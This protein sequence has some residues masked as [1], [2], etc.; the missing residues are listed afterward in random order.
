[1]YIHTCSI[2]T[3]LLLNKNSVKVKIKGEI[4]CNMKMLLSKDALRKELW[5]VTLLDRCNLVL[6]S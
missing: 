5:T 4:K 2:L 6:K 1:M 3:N